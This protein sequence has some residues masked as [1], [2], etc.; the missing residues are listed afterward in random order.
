[1]LERE[2]LAHR[3]VTGRYLRTKLSSRCIYTLELEGWCR[4]G[5]SGRLDCS[6]VD[7]RR[8]GLAGKVVVL[9]RKSVRGWFARTYR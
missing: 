3:S 9:T 1:M 7:S 8:E 6:E 4:G 5:D 2:V